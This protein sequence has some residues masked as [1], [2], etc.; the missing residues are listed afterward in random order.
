M[1]SLATKREPESINPSDQTRSDCFRGTPSLNLITF[2]TSVNKNS[3][4]LVPIRSQYHLEPLIREYQQLMQTNR[5]VLKIIALV[6]LT[7]R[8]KNEPLVEISAA[9][10]ALLNYSEPL[11]WEGKAWTNFFNQEIVGAFCLA[12][13]HGIFEKQAGGFGKCKTLVVS[14]KALNM[15]NEFCARSSPRSLEA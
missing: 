2:P 7:A 11:A 8:D 14:A 1:N 4:E 5:R 3:F 6:I 15:V 12:Y 9:K 13:K 10:K